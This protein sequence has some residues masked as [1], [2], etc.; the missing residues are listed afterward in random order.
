MSRQLVLRYVG[1]NNRSAPGPPQRLF[2]SDIYT[3][4]YVSL[5][6]LFQVPKSLGGGGWVGVK[7]K[8]KRSKK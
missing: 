4:S 3:F 6:K 5:V 7:D 2:F 8:N 1:S